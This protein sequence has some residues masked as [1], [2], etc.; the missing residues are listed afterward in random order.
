KYFEIT[1]NGALANRGFFSLTRP[2]YYK[3]SNGKEWGKWVQD[4]MT[5]DEISLQR[6]QFMHPNVVSFTGQ[7][8]VANSDNMT[9]NTSYNVETIYTKHDRKFLSVGLGL[10]ATSRNDGPS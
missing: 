10:H 1:P 3:D 7:R 4:G 9:H 6:N 2:D 8:Y 5:G